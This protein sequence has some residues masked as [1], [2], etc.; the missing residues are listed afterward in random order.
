M[1]LSTNTKQP[2]DIESLVLLLDTSFNACISG[3]NCFRCPLR[4]V[5]LTHCHGDINSI[6]RWQAIKT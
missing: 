2:L 6:E 1:K 3:A 4:A 5:G